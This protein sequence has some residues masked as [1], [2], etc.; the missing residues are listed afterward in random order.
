MSGTAAPTAA[1]YCDGSGF[2]SAL[3]FVRALHEAAGGRRDRRLVRTPTGTSEIDPTA[4]G[5]MVP[6]TFADSLIGSLYDDS[7]IAPLC[8]IRELSGPL[9]DFSVPGVDETSRADGSRWG[10]VSSYWSAEA[11]TVPNSLPRWKRLAFSARKLISL[12]YVTDEMWRDSALFETSVREAFA[13]EFGF[14]LDKNILSGS[15]LGVPLG[16][17]N[18]GALIAVPKQSGQTAATVLQGNISTMWARLPAP[19]RRRAVWLVNEDVESQFDN[20]AAGDRANVYMPAGVHGNAYPLLKGRPMIA[21]E[22]APALGTLGD[23]VLADLTAYLAVHAPPRF[24]LSAD[25]AFLS[26]QSVVRFILRIDG[27]PKWS[28]PIAPYNGAATRSPFVA[29]AAR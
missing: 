20:L 15:G 9:I 13:A 12:M 16:I 4:G 6:P 25:V 21:I 19:C 10:G 2:S 8:D 22:Q 1:P 28:S 23:I 18:S 29:L 3:E 26:D 17:L 24:A 27:K 7:L 14:Q 11:A 5:F